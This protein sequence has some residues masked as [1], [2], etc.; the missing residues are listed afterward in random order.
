MNCLLGMAEDSDNF[1]IEKDM[2][3]WPLACFYSVQYSQSQ[4][5]VITTKLI[6]SILS[7]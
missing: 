1:I 6:F 4:I 2:L 5:G 3:L 7:Q